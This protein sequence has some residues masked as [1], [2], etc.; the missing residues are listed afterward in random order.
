MSNKMSCDSDNN[1]NS[2]CENLSN[3]N[4][5]FCEND[6]VECESIVNL[7]IILKEVFKDF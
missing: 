4:L 1:Y 5:F 2:N 3:G 6:V 7:F